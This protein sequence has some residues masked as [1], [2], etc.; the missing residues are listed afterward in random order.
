MNTGEAHTESQ[1]VKPV[2]FVRTTDTGHAAASKCLDRDTVTL[3]GR[4]GGNRD[5]DLKYDD[6]LWCQLCQLIAKTHSSIK[7]NNNISG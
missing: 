3:R 1:I 7:E 2:S 6:K 5:W 4:R